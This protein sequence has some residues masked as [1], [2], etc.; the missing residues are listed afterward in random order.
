VD[1]VTATSADAAPSRVDAAA[2]SD[3]PQVPVSRDAD[4]LAPRD[5]ATKPRVDAATATGTATLN[6][7]ADPWGE[8]VIDGTKRGRTPKTVQVS[9]GPHTI[10]IV[11]GGEDPPR[12]KSFSVDLGDGEAKDLVADFTKP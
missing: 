3:A 12:T 8:I 1:A 4:A 5:A 7:G 11:F 6:I 9:A 10:E 2:H